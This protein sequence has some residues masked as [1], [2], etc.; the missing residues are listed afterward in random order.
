MRLKK[1]VS[2]TVSNLVRLCLKLQLT[3]IRGRREY[4]SIAETKKQKKKTKNER[5]KKYI[6]LVNNGSVCICKF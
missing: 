2:V 3:Q 1:A 6:E 4:N 5:R